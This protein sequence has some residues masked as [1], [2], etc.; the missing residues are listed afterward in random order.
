MAR[1]LKSL[2]SRMVLAVLLINAV[3]LPMLS[4]GMLTL[5]RNVQEDFFTD[6]VRIYSRVFADLLQANDALATEAEIVAGL[7][8]SILGGR[9]VYAAVNMGGS[10]LLSSLMEAADGDKFVEDF[11]F[12]EHDDG[13]YYLSIPL[14]FAETSAVLEL[15]FD[16][17]PTVL[18]IERAR[19]NILTIVFV[20]LLVTVVLVILLSTLVSRPLRRLRRDSRQV[21]SG[22]YS[23]QMSVK[24]EIFEISELT[25]DLE[26]MRSTLVGINDRLEGEIASREVAEAERRK[27]E[28]YLRHTHRLQSIGTLAG[29]VAHEF[30]NV[31]LP[32][33]LY[34]D[35]AL[36]DLPA[37]SP[38]R[39]NL[40][41]VMK[42]ANRAK[43]L[44]EQILT[45][46]RPA[47]DA[48]EATPDIAPVIDEAM[49]MVRALMPANIEIQLDIERPV[50][51][52]LCNPNE[53]QQLVV[54]LCSNAYQSLLSGRN[55]IKVVLENSRVTAEFAGK[56]PKL[57]EGAYIRLRVSDTGEGMDSATIERIFD[58]F[59]T[60]REVGKGTGLGLSVVHGI[61]VKHDG[62]IVVASEVGVGTTID[63]YFPQSDD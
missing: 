23:R 26:H 33:L 32:M 1:D 57:Q 14:Q 39:P 13:V 18:D 35:L 58:P 37:D 55:V 2:S 8:S 3:L 45:F 31:L 36:E 40:E 30:N 27:A 29:G 28:I 6:H 59:F 43:G 12:G 52:L 48:L 62:E 49:S 20:Y 24:S 63:V 53:I 61:V 34:T 9:C 56:H 5:V 44:S 25:R 38:V 21:A 60:T 41:R 11:Q 51:P 16:E 46:G 50:G 15:G 10:R 54:N 42:L 17:Q 22:D 7:D 4:Y 19:E 47:G